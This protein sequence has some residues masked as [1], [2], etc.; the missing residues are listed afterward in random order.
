M[1]KPHA[2]VRVSRTTHRGS[3]CSEAAA[4]RQVLAASFVC[5]GVGERREERV[6]HWLLGELV[7]L[8]VTHSM[9]QGPFQCTLE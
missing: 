2:K 1:C 6:G 3:P 7:P 4:P 9:R 5:V 8:T